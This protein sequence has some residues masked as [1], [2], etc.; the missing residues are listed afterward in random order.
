MPSRK[1]EDKK[2]EDKDI[3]KEKNTENEEV[4]TVLEAEQQEEKPDE[5]DLKIEHLNDMLLRTAA[6]YDNYRKRTSKQLIE[7]EADATVKLIAAILPVLD[8][9]ERAVQ[10]ECADENY[11]KGVEMILQ[12]FCDILKDMGAEQIESDGKPFDPSVHQA[13]QQV[14]SEE[15]ESGTVAATYQKGYRLGDKIIRFSVVAVAK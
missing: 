7:K 15:H 6:E 12:S 14:E 2:R 1:N 5:R 9:L 11:K 3:K 4:D 10:N 13:V 8:N